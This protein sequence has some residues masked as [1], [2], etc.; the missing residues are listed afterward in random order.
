VTLPQE[1]T[2]TGLLTR[3]FSMQN[4]AY[5]GAVASI[6]LVGIGAAMM[7]GSGAGLLVAG[8]ALGF[9]SYLLGVE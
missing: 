1:E 2:K 9:F 7:F 4:L 8:V 3:V 6:L 5:V